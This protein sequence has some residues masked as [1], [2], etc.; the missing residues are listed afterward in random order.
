MLDI[1]NDMIK[2]MNN[3]NLNEMNVLSWGSPIISFGDFRK[4]KIATIG[5]NPSNLEFVDAYGNELHGFKRRFQTL[6]SLGLESWS[7]IKVEHLK[8]ML[9]SC[10]TYFDGNP[11]NEWFKKLDFIISG[12]SISFY[13][14][15]YEACHLDLVPYTTSSKWAELSAIQ[16][17]SLL[18]LSEDYLGNILK[19]SSIRLLILNG[20]SV[21]DNFEKVS[22]TKLSRDHI[23]EWDLL[24]VKNK[25]V[26]G[27]SFYGNIKYFGGINFEQQIK[28]IGYNHNIQS[29]YGISKDILTSIRDWITLQ[30]KEVL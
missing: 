11:Y 2:G 20:K 29:S 16:K 5:L 24:R 8:L 23:P 18:G 19:Q 27:L 12:T 25:K 14:P 6:N 21:V 9:K 10:W 30:S 4:A 1:L 7:N 15:S 3:P 26:K 28:I 17:K 13:L 22:G